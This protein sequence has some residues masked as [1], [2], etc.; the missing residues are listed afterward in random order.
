VLDVVEK[1]LSTQVG[2]RSLIVAKHV[3]S[4]GNATLKVFNLVLQQ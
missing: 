4:S 2:Q 3:V 1:V